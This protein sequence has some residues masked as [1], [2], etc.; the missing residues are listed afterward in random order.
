MAPAFYFADGHSTYEDENEIHT[1]VNYTEMNQVGALLWV[2]H[3]DVAVEASVV[4]E[5]HD[6][7]VEGADRMI[8][9]SLF[10]V[11]RISAD[12]KASLEQFDDMDTTNEVVVTGSDGAP[13]VEDTDDGEE[14]LQS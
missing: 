11:G 1:W 9:L 12:Q 2:E 13:K 7:C 5:D 10:D 3:V 6:E 14:E 8:G 4:E